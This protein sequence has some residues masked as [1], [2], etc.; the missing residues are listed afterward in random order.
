MADFPGEYSVVVKE[1][2]T[3]HQFALN[4]D[5]PYHPA[6]TIKLP[7]TLYTLEQYRAGRANWQ[8]LIEYTP[9][10]YESPGG[11]AFEESPFGGLYPI[12]NLV[13]RSL[14]YSNNVA[15]NMLGRHFGW[16]NIEAWSRSI[17]GDIR[18]VD[19][20]LQVTAMSELGWWLHLEK[21]SREDPQSA[22]LLLQPLRQVTYD[23]RI[24]AG[25]PPGTPH[26]HKFGS[27]DGNFHDGGMIFTEQ[28][29]VLVILTHGA[30]EAEADSAIARL[31]GAIYRVMSSTET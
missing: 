5:L 8:D 2:Q 3:G 23:G 30:D 27:Y 29:Y 24:T 1:I 25:L 22:E 18:R 26:L 10:D 6:S 19:G 11:G 17:A 20:Q 14:I 12:E 21:L 15:V 13:N 9:A 31:S 28:P 7:V 16:S 4:A